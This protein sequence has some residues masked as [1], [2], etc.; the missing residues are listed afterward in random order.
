L[1][2]KNKLLDEKKNTSF[3]HSDGKMASL[4]MSSADAKQ[5]TFTEELKASGSLL[6][7]KAT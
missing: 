5:A 3:T 6:K 2:T 1:E 4:D 7:T